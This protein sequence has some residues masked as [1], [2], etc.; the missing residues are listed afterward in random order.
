MEE[1]NESQELS[2]KGNKKVTRKIIPNKKGKRIKDQYGDDHILVIEEQTYYNFTNRLKGPLFFK[3]ENGKEDF[4]EGGETK[5]DI[6]EKEREVLLNSEN[7]RNGWLVEEKEFI[8][9]SD[10]EIVNKNSLS[11]SELKK[12]IDKYK[13]DIKSLERIINGMSSDFAVSKMK[14]A[15]IE[16]NMPSSLVLLC[17]YR[18]QK[19]EEEYLE[20][21]KA[22]IDREEKDG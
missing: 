15:L 13:N 3:R 11:D 6:T 4:F 10:K 2:P 7:W 22:P 21:Q 9:S 16:E 1:K 17:D 14:D 20:K 19:I 8:P 12:L 18:L 5:R